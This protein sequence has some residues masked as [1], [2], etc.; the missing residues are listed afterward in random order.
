MPALQTQASGMA[1][2]DINADGTRMSYRVYVN[3][4][5]NVVAGHIHVAPR[6]ENGPVVVD[7]FGQGQPGGG[8]RNGL[9]AEG[10]FAADKLAGPLAGK[11]L[12]DLV[13]EIRN[14]RAYVNFHTNDGYD[15]AN[16]GPGDH[17]GGEIR[18]QLT[19]LG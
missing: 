10:S 13:A 11:T 18:G 7:L 12:Q 8:P 16:S 14:G 9:V 19:R 17:P 15:P 2:L 3:G 5:N 4:L 1:F 6:G